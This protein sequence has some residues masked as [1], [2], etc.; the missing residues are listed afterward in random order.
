MYNML[1]NNAICTDIRNIAM[2]LF[3]VGA[4]MVVMEDATFSWDG[5]VPVLKG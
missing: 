3:S 2:F 4:N 1:K 5:V